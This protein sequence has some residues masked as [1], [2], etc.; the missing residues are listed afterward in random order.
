MGLDQSIMGHSMNK[1]AIFDL[2]GVLADLKELHFEALNEALHDW[3]F[4]PITREEHL[5]RFDGLPT[6]VKL[7][8]L[9]ITGNDANRVCEK[10][11][12]ITLRRMPEFCKASPN[13]QSL[14]RNITKSGWAV[15]V[16]SNAK[17][18]TVELCLRLMGIY[19]L[20][21]IKIHSPDFVRNPAKPSPIMFLNMMMC[22]G[23]CPTHTVI[24]EDSPTGLYAAHASGAKVVQV[25]IPLCNDP[26]AE[27]F[28]LNNLIVREYY[29][30]EWSYLNVLIPAAGDG[31]RFRNA[32]FD[33][34]KPF[35]KMPDGR[36]MLENVVSNLRVRACKNFVVQRVYSIYLNQIVMGD[37]EYLTRRCGTSVVDGVTRGTAE[38]CLVMAP[39]VNSDQPLLIA[40]SD[41]MLEWDAAA[42]YYFC[43]NTHLDGVLVVFD[44]PER[45]H[46]W[47]YCKVGVDGLVKE[48]AE[49]APISSIANC[50][51]YF[52]KRG[53]DFV[54]YAR[55]MIEKDVRVN[56]EYYLA[57]VYNE[58][59][60]DGKKIGIFKVDKMWGL[61]DPESFKAYVESHPC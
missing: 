46:K 13:L 61:G 38:T 58:M 40:N 20:L 30:Y 21:A 50:G 42:F 48:V 28:V 23:S 56:G 35:I 44:C 59:I 19:H 60:A 12:E 7:E 55:Q 51:L 53:S 18:T 2:D 29:E 24:F 32:G 16:C 41:Q 45:D 25:D 1:L 33:R 26:M 49:K 5:T 36:T 15:G 34:P 11:Q 39:T 54:K 57:P 43:R 52:F 31:R 27:M 22:A 14:I 17:Y 47:S 10:K 6:M 3:M 37:G 4:E 9:G 8:M